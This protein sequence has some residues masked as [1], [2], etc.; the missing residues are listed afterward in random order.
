MVALNVWK[1]RDRY[2]RSIGLKCFARGRT[3]CVFLL[4]TAQL[5]FG[6]QGTTDRSAGTYRSDAAGAMPDVSAIAEKI[7]TAFSDGDLEALASIYADTVDYLDSG[8]ISSADVRRQ[9]AKYFARWPIR[10]WELT[11]PV[12][13][14]PTGASLHRVVFSAHYDVSNPDSNRH[15]AGIAIETLVVTSDATGA[16]KII[17]HQEK[18]SSSSGSNNKRNQGRSERLRIYDSKPVALLPPSPESTPP[19]LAFG[20]QAAQEL[21]PFDTLFATYRGECTLNGQL[22]SVQFDVVKNPIL[23]S[24]GADA[25]LALLPKNGEQKPIAIITMRGGMTAVAQP[26]R[27]TVPPTPLTKKWHYDFNAYDRSEIFGGNFRISLEQN[28]SEL[29][30]NLVL[31]GE[32]SASTPIVLTRLTAAPGEEKSANSSSSAPSRIDPAEI[33]GLYEGHYIT[34]KR[35][36]ALELNLSRESGTNSVSAVF[37]LSTGGAGSQTLGSYKLKGELNT[38][39]HEFDLKPGQWIGSSGGFKQVGLRGVFDPATGKLQGEANPEKGTFEVTRNEQKTAELQA[40]TLAEAKKFEAAPVAFAEARS[41]DERRMV[42]VRWF[43]RLKK[44]Y[45]DLDLHHTVLDKIY[46]KTLNLYCDPD[47]APVFGKPFDSM[48]ADERKYV[49]QSLRRLFNGRETR[50]LLDGFGD[51][52]GRPFS[53][54]QGSFSY[55][56]VAPQIAFRRGLSKK[57]QQSIERLKQLPGSSDAFNEIAALKKE[58]EETF[59]DLWPSQL[60]EFLDTVEA[61]RHRIA[62]GALVERLDKSLSAAS[63]YDGIRQLH[64]TLNNNQELFS[65]V[66]ESTRS[67]EMARVREKLDAELK[68]LMEAERKK[69]DNFDSGAK[70]L[71]NGALWWRT[72]HETYDIPF[73]DVAVVQETRKYMQQRRLSALETGEKE[74]IAS[75]TASANKADVD[76]KVALYAGLP[77]DVDT[78]AGKR[79]RKAGQDRIDALAWEKEKE[80][81]SERELALM[82]KPGVIDVPAS[83]PAPTTHEIGLAMLRAFASTGGEVLSADTATFTPARMFKK[84]AY[85]MKVKQIELARAEPI[86][87]GGYECEYRIFMK[88]DLPDF[89]SSSQDG[90]AQMYNQFMQQAQK[91]EEPGWVTSKLFLTPTGW[92][93]PDMESQVSMN[94]LDLFMPKK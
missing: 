12:N 62:E 25:L 73:G 3:T 21:P 40:K 91:L 59:A 46:P 37:T 84:F 78:E 89:I 10:H 5:A 43:S 92:R 44:E 6:Q 29:M 66:S 74:A 56:D 38:A 11:G 16:M 83:Y 39:T 88:F 24:G 57:W 79:V 64:D 52:L 41:D 28:G 86:S 75:V 71:V 9:I 34:N 69:I 87:G 65:L 76:N 8:R 94:S 55:A 32:Q 51:F 27:R 22:L 93:S 68:P 2:L 23:V 70:A 20:Q 61:T 35:Q 67:R 36:F 31:S 26:R 82:S 53:L 30:G 50:D 13:V 49:M 72:F 85:R 81:Y 14:Q 58:G 54:P 15:S 60:K 77:G 45:P 7:V 48:T 4:F 80:K 47:F 33:T 42:I 18:T 63:G 90:F 17:S 19:Q 1:G